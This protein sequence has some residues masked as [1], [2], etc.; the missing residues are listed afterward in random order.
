MSPTSAEALGASI[1]YVHGRRWTKFEHERTNEEGNSC[2]NQPY[3]GTSIKTVKY[4]E[5]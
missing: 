4:E 3:N 2:P 5:Q 1:A